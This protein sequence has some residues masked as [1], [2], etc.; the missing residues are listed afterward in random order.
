MNAQSILGIK[1]NT[2]SATPA[3]GTVYLNVTYRNAQ[4]GY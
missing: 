2:A 1:L 4:Y 3:S